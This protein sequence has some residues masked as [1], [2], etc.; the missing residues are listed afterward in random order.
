MQCGIRHI[1]I[2]GGDSELFQFFRITFRGVYSKQQAVLE[3]YHY[4][5]FINSNHSFLVYISSNLCKSK[6]SGV[7]VYQ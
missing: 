7:T 6:Q 2:R 1:L 4:Y 5:G 3:F